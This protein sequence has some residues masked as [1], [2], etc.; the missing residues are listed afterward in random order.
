MPNANNSCELLTYCSHGKDWTVG[1]GWSQS[2]IQRCLGPRSF[3]PG[4]FPESPSGT[5]SLLYKWRNWDF[6]KGLDLPQSLPKL[7]A[8]V[9]CVALSRPLS[10][11]S[12][13]SQTW[14]G[15]VEEVPKGNSHVYTLTAFSS[16]SATAVQTVVSW[17]DSITRLQTQVCPGAPEETLESS[18]AFIDVSLPCFPVQ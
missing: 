9:S 1:L 17:T 16:L 3:L 4:R 7:L 6:Q 2:S 10:L 18:T 14:V 13:Y 15:P 8:S 12:T 5:T 11:I